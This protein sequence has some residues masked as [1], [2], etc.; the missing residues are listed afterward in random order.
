MIRITEEERKQIYGILQ[1]LFETVHGQAL[2]AYLTILEN[3]SI[4]QED[5]ATQLHISK[6]LVNRVLRELKTYGIILERTRKKGKTRYFLMNP[7]MLF[8]IAY[9]NASKEP[10][11]FREIIP[12]DMFL[13][14]SKNTRDRLVNLWK[15]NKVGLGGEEAEEFDVQGWGG[16]IALANVCGWI[17][18]FREDL[19]DEEIVLVTPHLRLLKNEVFR[20]LLKSALENLKCTCVFFAESKDFFKQLDRELP[21]PP[22]TYRVYTVPR[23]M[24]PE[25][26]RVVLLGK[27]LAAIFLKRAD[28]YVGRMYYKSTKSIKCFIDCLSS[29]KDVCST[30]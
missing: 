21:G 5:I 18:A 15:S 6:P 11:S 23:F 13:E 28:H 1:P 25:Y 20:V 3:P 26:L 24:F 19:V 12:L 30:L 14:N 22:I 2:K 29:L 17:S 27:V 10:D 8:Y 4:T 9:I 16:E 7:E